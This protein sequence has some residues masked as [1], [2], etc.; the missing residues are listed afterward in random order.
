MKPLVYR[1]IVADRLYEQTD[2]LLLCRR[3]F[4]ALD[5]KRIVEALYIE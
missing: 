4:G 2:H 1:D 5:M 3:G